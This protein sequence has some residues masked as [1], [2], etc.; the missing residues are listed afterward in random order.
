MKLQ[1]NIFMSVFFYL[2]W[3]YAQAKNVDFKLE[4]VP[5]PKAVGNDL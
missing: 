1:R 4:S 2:F 3:G 5:L